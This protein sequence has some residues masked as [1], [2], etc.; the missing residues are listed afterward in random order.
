MIDLKTYPDDEL[1]RQINED[2]QL[3]EDYERA[4]KHETFQ[5][6]EIILND[7]FLYSP[8]QLEVL[9]EDFIESL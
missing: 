4:I 2:E 9:H 5:S 1:L 7:I 3:K 6:I 8:E